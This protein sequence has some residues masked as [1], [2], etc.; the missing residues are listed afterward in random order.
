MASYPG[1]TGEWAESDNTEGEES[2]AIGL[3]F[4]IRKYRELAGL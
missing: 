4:T 1:K 2:A 3:P